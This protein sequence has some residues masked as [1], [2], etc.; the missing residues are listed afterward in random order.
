[1]AALIGLHLLVTWS[2]FVFRIDEFPLTWAPMYAVQPKP[3]HG[4]W[5][6]VRKDRPRLEREGWRAVRAD[7]GEEWVRRGD[8]NVPTRNMWRLYYERTWRKPPPRYKHKNSG[9]ATLD[10]LV[11]GLPP[12]A[13]IY[14]ANWERSLLTSVNRTLGRVPEDPAFLVALHAERMRMQFDSRTKQKLGETLERDGPLAP[15]VE[16]GLSALSGVGGGSRASCSAAR[17]QSASPRPG[18]SWESG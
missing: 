18:C 12:G 10:R 3:E 17:P 16:R 9:G 6:V 14:T 13:P 1:V 5:T 11:L 8:L 15:R 7:G 4:I 2:A